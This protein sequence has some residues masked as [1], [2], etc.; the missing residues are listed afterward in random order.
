MDICRG[1]SVEKQ[2]IEA[3][4]DYTTYLFLSPS[5]LLHNREAKV[6]TVHSPYDTVYVYAKDE[7]EQKIYMLFP[8]RR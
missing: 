2:L 8:R 7:T 1:Y 6:T 3:Y 5:T 4:E